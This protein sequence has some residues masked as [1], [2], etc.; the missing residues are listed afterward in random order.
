MI[1]F[2]LE[3]TSYSA[4]VRKPLQK[5]IGPA[6]LG[7]VALYLVG[8]GEPTAEGP[9]PSSQTQTSETT[10]DGGGSTIRTQ[11][12]G[13][14]GFASNDTV[15]R[16]GNG[17]EPDSLD[18][19]KATGTWESTIIGDMIM[20]LLTEDIKG[21]A[22]AGSAESW[23]ISP[24]G[25]IYTFVIREGLLWSDGVPVTAHDFVYSF[26][27]ILNPA[28]A[29]QY[30][31]LLYLIKNAQAVNEGDMDPEGVGV[32]AIDAGTLQITLENPAPFFLEL[33]THQT[34]APVPM[35]KVEELGSAWI[36]D[37]NFVGNGA[38]KLAEWVPQSHVKIVKNDLFYD[39]EH[40]S[41]EEAIFIPTVDSS[42]ALK[43]FRAGELDYNRGAPLQ[44]IDWMK[45]NLPDEFIVYPYM[46]L[47][48]IQINTKIDQVQ[49][50][51]VGPAL[52]N[53]RVR[54]ALSMALEREA[55]T[56]RILRAG[57]T[58]AY[59]FVPPGIN[60]HDRGE[61]MSF[62]GVPIAQ[63]VEMAKTILAEEGYG[64]DN[65]LSFEYKYREGVD[66]KRL[67]VA[68][69]AM[70]QRIGVKA[71]LMKVE[72]KTHYSDMRVGKFA[73][74]DAGWIADYNDAQNFLYLLQT[75]TGEMNYGK[76][77]NSVF[78]AL[79]D[80]ANQTLDLTKRASLMRQA[81]AI[82]LKEQP[83]IPT[84]FAS[85]QT[86]LQTYVKGWEP[87]VSHRHRTRYIYIDRSS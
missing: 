33:L 38:Y 24:D 49:Y 51:V 40:V 15:L 72:V 48:Y 79:M 32:K 57:Q 45:E 78:D 61:R 23:D 30:A 73:V 13:K 53:P 29:S 67:A 5:L 54:L 63:R 85:S 43:M 83:L 6:A 27:R 4:R 77:S 39:A 2:I 28:T 19:H 11:K 50:P 8:C 26:Q 55:M 81:E 35:H 44:Q 22:I 75:S 47:S 69:R 59:A 7:V 46:G 52:A 71:N 9:E 56:D 86:L 62:E 1:D 12:Q 42:A 65:P 82:I 76:Y 36:K 80:E 16:I 31:S 60:N 70:W 68:A 25:L 87:N 74:A 21:R 64:P 34:T 17:A 41:I 18:P 58:P 10:A 84:Y 14:N 3:Q 20:G 37:V 66:G